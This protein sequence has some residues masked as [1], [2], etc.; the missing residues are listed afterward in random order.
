VLFFAIYFHLS[1]NLFLTLKNNEVADLTHFSTKCVFLKFLKERN[2]GLSSNFSK[3]F[4]KLQSALET[5][6][7]ILI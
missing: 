2:G 1:K 6:F 7:S 5:V 4:L 3:L